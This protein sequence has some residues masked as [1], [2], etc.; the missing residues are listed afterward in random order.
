M[1]YT[2]TYDA[3]GGIIKTITTTG[4]T[5]NLQAK[6]V[7]PSSTRQTINPDTGYVGMSQVVVE[8]APSSSATIEALSI[9][10]SESAQTFNFFCAEIFFKFKISY[11]CF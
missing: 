9:T 4:D 10:P 6:T 11:L 7:T 3:N 2:V 1:T 8:A 5:T